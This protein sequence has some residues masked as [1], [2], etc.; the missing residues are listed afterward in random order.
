MINLAVLASGSGTNAENLIKYFDEHESIRVTCVLTNNPKAGVLERACELGVESH[1]FDRKSFYQVEAVL[2]LLED[3]SINVIVLAGFLWLIPTK[4]I[5]YYPEKIINIHPSLLPKYGGKGMY[6]HHVHQAVLENGEVKSGITVHL[7]NEVYDQGQIL[8]QT[9][10]QVLKSDTP[11][12][13]ANRIHQLEYEHFP[14]IIEQ[15][16]ITI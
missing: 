9:T 6:G 7:V 4:I 13:L 10:C 11:D 3:K 16:V 1:V 14:K 5:N 2:N 8:F 12:S 15:Y